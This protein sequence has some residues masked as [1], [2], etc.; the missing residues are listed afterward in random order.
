MAHKKKKK[1]FS[2]RKLI[3]NDK[4]LIIFSIVCALVIWIGTSMSLSPETTKTITVS[5]VADFSESAAA[6]LGLK[7]YGEESINVD[8][9]VR[10][11]KYLAKDITADD[12]IT[13]LQTN[14][15]TESGVAQVPIR[16][17]AEDNSDF[18]ILS[19]YPTTYSAF[20]DVEAQKVMDVN[21]NFGDEKIIADGY[22]LGQTILSENSLT[23]TGPATYVSRVSSIECDVNL[24]GEELSASKNVSISP[25]ALDRYDNK[26]DY[27]SLLDSNGKDVSLLDLTIPVLKQTELPVA[28]EFTNK[29]ASLN[30]SILD[31]SYSVSRVNAGVIDDVDIKSC[32]IGQIDFSH[33][34]VGKN[35]FTFDVQNLDSVVILDGITEIKV[36]VNVPKDYE[37]SSI[38]VTAENVKVSNLPDGYKFEVVSMSNYSVTSIGTAKQLKAVSSKNVTLTV[39]AKQLSDNISEGTVTLDVTPSI[40]GGEN[41][42][43]Y[44]EY[45][46]TI[47]IYK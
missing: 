14:Y 4:Y 22:I 27:I 31:V 20:F 34:T 7:C 37:S 40:E 45:T 3:Y 28:V 15:V 21:I 5:V 42:W 36:T 16:V 35:E 2:I 9:N 29:P 11:K 33:L 26:V 44:G 17:Q 25:V 6:Q 24:Q 46:A 38:P 13:S 23:V 10:C 18:E 32:V 47:N 41:C 39:N 1:S 43:I 19:F 30:E 12:F 8:V